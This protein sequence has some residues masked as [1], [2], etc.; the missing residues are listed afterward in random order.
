MTVSER[1][2]R[3]DDRVLGPAE[4]HGYGV[5]TGASLGE[6]LVSAIYLLVIVVAAALSPGIAFYVAAGGLPVYIGVR[7]LIRL[8][9]NK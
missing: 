3:M 2:R 7:A 6:R 9:R 8:A 5:L 4:K 1:L